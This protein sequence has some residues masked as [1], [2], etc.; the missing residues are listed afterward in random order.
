MRTLELALLVLCAG[1][2]L[3]AI[4]YFLQLALNYNPFVG[5]VLIA[6]FLGFVLI[7][8]VLDR[9]FNSGAKDEGH[10]LR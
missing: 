8:I 5:V 10:N 3:G 9:T 1:M 4:I 6:C 2:F 7:G